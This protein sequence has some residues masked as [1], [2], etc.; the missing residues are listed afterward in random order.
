M[1]ATE[2]TRTESQEQEALEKF[3]LIGLDYR[4]L[5][6]LSRFLKCTCRNSHYVNEFCNEP[7][8]VFDWAVLE[9]PPYKERYLVL[10]FTAPKRK[11]EGHGRAYVACMDYDEE[12][13][14]LL[15]SLNEWFRKG[16]GVLFTPRRE[17]ILERKGLVWAVV[18]RRIILESQS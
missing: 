14:R 6:L 12:T 10:A 2:E 17:E 13:R 1:N 9:R 18:R 16:W 15:E 4:S 7:I 3:E 8:R 11:E 5:Q